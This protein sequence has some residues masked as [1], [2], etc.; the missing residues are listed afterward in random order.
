MRA[1]SR[2]GSVVHRP[3]RH[4]REIGKGVSYNTKYRMAVTVAA[5]EATVLTATSEQTTPKYPRAP[6]PIRA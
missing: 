2:A 1:K 4:C 5:I 3:R 6:S